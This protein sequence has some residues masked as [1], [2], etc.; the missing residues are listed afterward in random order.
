MLKIEKTSEQCAFS[1]HDRANANSTKQYGTLDDIP[2]YALGSLEQLYNYVLRPFQRWCGVIITGPLEYFSSPNGEKS[3]GRRV[4]MPND[5]QTIQIKYAPLCMLHDY[6]DGMALISVRISGETESNVRTCIL[7]TPQQSVPSATTLMNRMCDPVAPRGLHLPIINFFRQHCMERVSETSLSCSWIVT[8]AGEGAVRSSTFS[9]TRNVP[10]GVKNAAK[11]TRKADFADFIHA[12]ATSVSPGPSV[13]CIAAECV[14]RNLTDI[15]RRGCEPI[16]PKEYEK[17]TDRHIST[18]CSSDLEVGNSAVAT[19]VSIS[20]MLSA[21]G[22]IGLLSQDFFQDA[23]PTRIKSPVGMGMVICMAVRIAMKP[24]EFRQNPGTINDQI[25]RQEV[26]TIFESQVPCAPLLSEDRR[27]GIDVAI[28]MA[29]REVEKYAAQKRIPKF[30]INDQIS[31]WYRIGQGLISSMFGIYSSSDISIPSSKI[32]NS[33]AWKFHDPIFC[34]RDAKMMQMG[35]NFDSIRD[36]PRFNFASIAQRRTTFIKLMVE[37]E[38]YIRSGNFEGVQLFPRTQRK[39]T[40]L[41]DVEF[42]E[43][44]VRQAFRSE[45][46][47]RAEKGDDVTLPTKEEMADLVWKNFNGPALIQAHEDLS[48]A[49]LNGPICNLAKQIQCY[50]VSEYQETPCCECKRPVHVL[51]GVVMMR[52]FGKCYKCNARRCLQC[53]SKY[54]LMETVQAKNNLSPEDDVIYGPNCKICG[55]ESKIPGIPKF[56]DFKMFLS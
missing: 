23:L 51:Q 16:H 25:A 45:I 53:S 49:L 52:N 12:N 47:A 1:A 56:L 5:F 20:D 33:R 34:A 17:L 8:P 36:P 2:D 21:E 46:Q 54:S 22:I 3:W 15:I 48:E 7:F 35:A 55:A 24:L 30:Q 28:S 38:K 14:D 19:A 50:L 10:P 31:Y 11:K 39:D 29:M 41:D 18:I 6:Y 43:E 32:P 42:D 4:S 37:T 44:T 9:L 13:L 27:Y 26:R 40:S